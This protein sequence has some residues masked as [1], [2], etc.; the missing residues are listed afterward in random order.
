MFLQEKYMLLIKCDQTFHNYNFT[1]I[2]KAN[3]KNYYLNSLSLSSVFF[4]YLVLK[5]F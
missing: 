5:I 3:K 2:H 4:L 1:Y